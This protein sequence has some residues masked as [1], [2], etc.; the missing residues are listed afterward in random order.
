MNDCHWRQYNLLNLDFLNGTNWFSDML[1]AQTVSLST[2]TYF[3]SFAMHTNDKKA[4]PGASPN[5]ALPGTPGAGCDQ[6]RDE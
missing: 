1:Y 4:E 5:P 6:E 3:E 2:L